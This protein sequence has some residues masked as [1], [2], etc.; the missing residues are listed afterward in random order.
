MKL[1]RLLY[2]RS[3]GASGLRGNISYLYLNYSSTHS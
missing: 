2:D 1:G 3:L